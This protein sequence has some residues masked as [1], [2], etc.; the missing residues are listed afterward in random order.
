MCIGE[1][2]MYV[3]DGRAIIGALTENRNRRHFKT[4]HT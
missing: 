1:E 3:A 4:A 2:H